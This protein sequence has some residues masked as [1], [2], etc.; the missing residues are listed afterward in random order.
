MSRNF[1]KPKRYQKQKNWDSM[2]MIC[3]NDWHLNRN[4]Y[5]KMFRCYNCNYK[6]CWKCIINYILNELSDYNR[7]PYCMNCNNIINYHDIRVLCYFNENDRL[8]KLYHNIKVK[9]NYNTKKSRNLTNY[10]IE[11][12]KYGTDLIGQYNNFAKYVELTYTIKLI[13]KH[14]NDRIS[15]LDLGC[16]SGGDLFK[17]RGN[18]TA[19]KLYCGIDIANVSVKKARNRYNEMEYK[20]TNILMNNNNNN[21]NNFDSERKD[22]YGYGNNAFSKPFFL[23]HNSWLEI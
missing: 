19:I 3:N 4:G 16:G 12:K 10:G 13:Y 11:L 21:N 2:S 5:R 22:C 9:Q 8:Y 20:Y 1:Y 18:N 14:K 15:V 17:Y 23:M 7:I 6:F